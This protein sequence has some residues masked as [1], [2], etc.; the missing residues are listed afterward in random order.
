MLAHLLHQFVVDVGDDA[1]FGSVVLYQYVQS[2]A[3]WH[4][5]NET[6]VMTKR[7]NRVPSNTQ[8]LFTSLAVNLEQSVDQTEQLHHTLVLTNVFV[9]F[10]QK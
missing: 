10:K 6:S 2:V 7:Y 3:A 1:V 8:V 4:P 9:A 5:A